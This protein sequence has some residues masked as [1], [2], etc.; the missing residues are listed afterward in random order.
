MRA[1]ERYDMVDRRRRKRRDVFAV[2]DRQIGLAIGLV[3]RKR[4][5][6]NRAHDFV[7]D[8]GEPHP[9]RCALVCGNRK[10]PDERVRLG[11]VAHIERAVF[12]DDAVDRPHPRD[13]IAPSCRPSGNRY[14]DFPRAA[15]TLERAVGEGGDAAAGRQRVIDVGEDKPD[16][17]PHRI[18]HCRQGH[19]H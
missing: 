7:G 17:A 12:A 13:V 16:P 10:T 18:G 8:R 6:R 4:A 3:R 15:Q 9:S 11:V 5:S 2:I 14:D 19:R 1:H